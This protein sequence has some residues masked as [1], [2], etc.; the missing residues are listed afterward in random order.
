M[1]VERLSKYF[2]VSESL[3]WKIAR[4]ASH[5][6]KVYEIPK[7]T[8]GS[9]QIAQ[10]SRELKLIQRWISR[11]VVSLLPVHPAAAAYQKG[12]NILKNCKRHAPQRYLLRLDVRNFFGSIASHHLL[13]LIKSFDNSSGETLTADDLTFVQM[14]CFRHN[15]LSIGAPSSPAI[16]NVVM[17][18]FDERIAQYCA[19]NSITYSRYADDLYFSTNQSNVLS[20]VV[21]VVNETLSLAG[22]DSLK[23]NLEKLVFAS[24]KRRR[25]VTGLTISPDGSIS[26]GRERKREIRHDVFRYSKGLMNR[27]S[28][29]QLAGRLAF[30]ISIDLNF[31]SQLGKAFEKSLIDEL[32]SLSSRKARERK[33]ADGSQH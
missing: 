8:G 23:L 21:P 14:I 32:F 31:L 16:S 29:M 22:L 24:P 30:A 20:S 7:R 26:I 15:V 33:S 10:P 2:R 12:C 3:C 19:A 1:L 25:I 27:K 18:E 17:Y 5:R 28:A 11:E 9:R 13:S 6:Y 4:T